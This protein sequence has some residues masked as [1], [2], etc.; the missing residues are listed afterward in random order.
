MLLI[1]IFLAIFFRKLIYYREGT[2]NFEFRTIKIS[3]FIP[4]CV[5]CLTLDKSFTPLIFKYLI[6]GKEK[7]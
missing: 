2:A 6:L 4:L 5:R 7:K 1:T 3:R